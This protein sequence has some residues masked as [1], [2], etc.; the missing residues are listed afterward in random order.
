MSYFRK[1][2]FDITSGTAF[3]AYRAGSRN[4]MAP[5]AMYRPAAAGPANLTGL[6]AHMYGFSPRPKRLPVQ[7]LGEPIQDL[8]TLGQPALNQ[9]AGLVVNAMWPT[10]QARMDEQLKPLKMFMGVTAAASLAAAVFGFLVWNKSSSG[11]GAA[12]WQM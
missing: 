10:L 9:A 8:L 2:A 4:P 3:E 11:A 7:G 12:A 5:Q 6:G 1:S